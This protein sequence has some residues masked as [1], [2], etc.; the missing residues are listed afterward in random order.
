MRMGRSFRAVKVEMGCLVA[1]DELLR[2]LFSMVTKANIL[3]GKDS[4]WPI[5]F[6]VECSPLDECAFAQNAHQVRCIKRRSV[7]LRHRFSLQ[8]QGLLPNRKCFERKPW[9]W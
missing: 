5:H 4:M 3:A 7:G 1:S 6:S 8:W 9:T 2:M